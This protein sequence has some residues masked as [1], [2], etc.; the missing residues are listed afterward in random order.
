MLIDDQIFL[1][2]V[3]AQEETTSVQQGLETAQDVGQR[4]DVEIENLQEQ[5]CNC[6]K[7]CFH[8][9]L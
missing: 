9:N 5:V 6:L 4:K 2:V 3:Q 8:P 7:A 1:L